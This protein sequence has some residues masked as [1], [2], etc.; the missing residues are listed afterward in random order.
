MAQLQ[1][2]PPR[3][4][5]LLAG[6]P[7][8][9]VLQ[10]RQWAQVKT[11]N[12]WQPYHHLWSPPGGV[13]PPA[14]ALILQRKL[15]LRG[16]SALFRVLYVPK[17]PLLDWDNAALRRKVLDGLAVIARRQGAVFI[18]ID[19]DVPLGWGV[20]GSPEACE[21]PTGQQLVSE[22]T[23]RGWH[24][25]DE[26]IQF[27][28]TVL[29][30][31][32]PS[33]E[34]LLARMKQKTRYNIR[35]AER[36]G[37]TIRSG[38]TADL[39]M[40]YKLYAQTSVRDGFVIRDA[41]YYLNTWRIFL[42]AGLGKILIAESGGETLSAVILFHFQERAYYM[43]GM[44][45]ENQREKMPNYLLQWEAMRTLKAAGCR[46]YDLWGAPDEFNE[47][48]S[49]WGVYRFK[50][51][52]GGTVVRHIGAWDLPIQPLFYKLY[53]QTLPRLLE[54]MRQ[55]GR[56]RTRQIAGES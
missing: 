16:F 31:L 17:G 55:R 44:S 19:P 51:G 28:N 12:N 46:W 30:D 3:W 9:H 6:L 42:E 1:P 50:E 39:P 2:L 18:K 11:Q 29:L 10:T 37:V 32:A 33:E 38:S 40:L 15:P 22:L 21:N 24:L 49:M 5:D 35:L 23:Q 26:Q 56:E 34:A 52:L 53:T 13:Q 45:S 25:S 27:R 8:P 54:W 36:K 14:G 43:F 20:P 7:A 47:T 48:D 41:A 4:N